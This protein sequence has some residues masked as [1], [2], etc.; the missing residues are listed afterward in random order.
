LFCSDSGSEPPA[1]E[2]ERIAVQNR[3]PSLVVRSS[4][5]LLWLTAGNT[6][7]AQGFVLA[8]AIS[9]L[10]TKERRPAICGWAIDV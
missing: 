10:M 4:R 2:F 3:G 8:G 1:L 6:R 5:S 9:I 7:A